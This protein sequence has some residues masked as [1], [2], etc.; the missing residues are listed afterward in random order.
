MREMRLAVGAMAGILIILTLVT[1]SEVR[2]E[3]AGNQTNWFVDVEEGIGF[4]SNDDRDY[5]NNTPPTSG[6]HQNNTKKIKNYATFHDKVSINLEKHVVEDIVI[7]NGVGTADTAE[8]PKEP[9]EPIDWNRVFFW[10]F[11]LVGLVVVGVVGW[12]VYQI[13]FY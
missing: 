13:Y 3:T 12:Y 8:K 1:A 6:T 7:E 5:V 11:I 9:R 2:N 4:N 10:I